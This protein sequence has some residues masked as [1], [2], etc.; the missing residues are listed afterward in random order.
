MTDVQEMAILC[1]PL[2]EEVRSYV[3]LQGS[4]ALAMLLAAVN[5]TAVTSADMPN[6]EC[7][8][9]IFLPERDPAITPVMQVLTSEQMDSRIDA[10]ESAAIGAH[11]LMGLSADDAEVVFIDHANPSVSLWVYHSDDGSIVL[12]ATF[13]QLRE[14]VELIVLAEV[15]HPGTGTIH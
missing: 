9:N 5:G 3:D 10:G 7:M 15:S 1:A 4:D 14:L 6:V 8:A 11:I 2:F 13:A 12:L